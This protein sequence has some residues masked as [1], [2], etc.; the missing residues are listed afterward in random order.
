[1]AIGVEGQFYLKF[2]IGNEEDFLDKDDL[3]GF[4]VYEYP[5]NV[6]PTFVLSFRTREESVVRNLNEGNLIQAQYGKNIESLS[7]VKLS[8]S[9][10]KVAKEGADYTYFDVSGYASEINYITDHDLLITEEVSAI[11]ASI[12]V[13]QSSGF[14]VEGNITKSLDKQ[15]WI[16]PNITDKAFVNDTYLRAVTPDNSSV[17]VAI[18]A[19]GKFI[20]KDIK[21]YLNTKS[22]DPEQPY[23]W[24]FTKNPEKERD[25]P[26]D[27]DTITD[28]QSGL[29][30]NWLGYGREIKEINNETGE[31]N[32]ILENPEVVLA[33]SKDLDKLKSV[34]DRYGGSRFR[35]DNVHEAFH[36]SHN[37]NLLFLANLSKI[38]ET[39]SV[40][41]E[42]FKIKPLDLAMFSI[43]STESLG[44]SSDYR[45]GMFLVSGLVRTFQANKIITTVLLNR[46]AFNEVKNEA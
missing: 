12:T 38:E 22:A 43:E 13:A 17:A 45:S 44:E 21:K 8:P 25:Y 4:T 31:V 3:V 39:L 15:R 41:D 14:K 7:D 30:N 46:D 24:K 19:D 2:K 33:L 16:Q 5:G 10:L 6:L 1:M 23:D 34:G 37:H 18:T 35:S 28:S 26:Y 27:A 32:T 40:S 42:F 11:E 29:I 9:I 36:S 20:I